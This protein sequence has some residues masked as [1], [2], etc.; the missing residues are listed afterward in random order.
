MAPV[1]VVMPF[2]FLAFLA[3]QDSSPR[4]YEVAR[5][6]LAQG[7]TADLQGVVS[8]PSGAT[9][10]GARVRLGSPAVGLVRETTSREVAPV[11][12]NRQV[13]PR[14]LALVQKLPRSRDPAFRLKGG[15]PG[16]KTR[17][18]PGAGPEGV[19]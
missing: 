13:V 17:S 7:N 5:Y 14:L 3:V 12:V 4:R 11:A 1:L 19:R 18:R 2:A 9:V 15:A 10:S 6:V 16:T 8:D